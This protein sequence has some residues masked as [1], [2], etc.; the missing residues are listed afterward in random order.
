MDLV[1]DVGTKLVLC[2]IQNTNKLNLDSFQ[3]PFTNT[4][5]NQINTLNKKTK[6]TN[7]WKIY[8]WLY[9]TLK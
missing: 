2:E 6:T 1:N 8:D 7:C 3:N 9:M 5:C 4:N